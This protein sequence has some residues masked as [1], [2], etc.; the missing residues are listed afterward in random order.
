MKLSASAHQ[1]IESFLR[2]HTG[3]PD[4]KLPH[5]SIHAGRGARM[6]M[7]FVRMGAI[8]LGSHVFVSRALVWR[9][10]LGRLRVPGR[11][12]VHEAI[13]VLQ[14]EKKGFLGF[15]YLYLR[16]YWRALR[17]GRSW[18]AAARM[19]AYLKIIEEC[20]ARE[21]EHAY[22]QYEKAVNRQT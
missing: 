11:L 1:E 20:E 13:H 19:A 12:V 10:E 18:N 17:E 3:E 21:A 9:D 8:T 16:G 2:E 4:L 6:L 5:F 22:S 7:W 14:Y 15:L